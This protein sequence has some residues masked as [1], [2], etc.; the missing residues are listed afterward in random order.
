MDEKRPS[1]KQEP[2]QEPIE[3]P[4]QPPTQE[5][6]QAPSRAIKSILGAAGS[7]LVCCM[8]FKDQWFAKSFHVRDQTGEYQVEP[9]LL[10]T[11]LAILVVMTLISGVIA[12][13]SQEVG[14]LRLFFQGI[15]LPGIIIVYATARIPAVQVAN[16][17]PPEPAQPRIGEGVRDERPSSSLSLARSAFA[18]QVRPT[19]EPTPLPHLTTNDV[20]PL[21]PPSFFVRVGWGVQTMFGYT[22]NWYVEADRY[23]GEEQATVVA[24]A[25]RDLR[26]DA[27]V[28]KLCFASP[29]SGGWVQCYAETSG[30]YMEYTVLLGEGLAPVEARAL[31]DRAKGVD[32]DARAWQRPEPRVDQP[33]PGE[34]Q[35]S[36]VERMGQYVVRARGEGVAIAIDYRR[37]ARHAGGKWLIL[38]VAMSG[39]GGT[40]MEVA[41]GDFAVKHDA[42][43]PIAL[44]TQEEFGANYGALAAD[45]RAV[46]RTAQT[47]PGLFPGEEEDCGWYLKAPGAGLVAETIPV[48]WNRVCLGFLA[49]PAPQGVKEGQWHLVIRLPRG[50]ELRVPFKL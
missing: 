36:S 2:S 28:R 3:E 16:A 24:N 29:A 46:K 35:P 34:A 12:V 45:L 47:L 41:R 9:V 8:W 27:R 26:L 1:H 31:Q 37:A 15:S 19:P 5:P 33:P 30:Q 22:D 23:A 40:S 14:H 38:G 20:T 21:Q 10:V 25:L 7:F 6:K 18:R 39:T 17:E 49:F 13:G 42:Y 43:P 4:K 32:V 11:F 50:K 48:R 44:A